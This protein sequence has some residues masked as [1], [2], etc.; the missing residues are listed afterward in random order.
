MKIFGFSKLTSKIITSIL[1]VG[2]LVFLGISLVM[3]GGSSTSSESYK[4]PEMAELE[5]QRKRLLFEKTYLA[6]YSEQLQA[7]I[8]DLQKAK[9]AFSA[10]PITPSPS[11]TPLLPTS[12]PTKETVLGVERVINNDT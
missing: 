4:S 2:L 11:P 6:E 9:N 5:L 3:D 1:L 7:D 8:A 10:T 12:N